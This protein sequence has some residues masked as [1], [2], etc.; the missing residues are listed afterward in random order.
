MKLRIVHIY[1]KN[2]ALRTSLIQSTIVHIYD[3]IAS[4]YL[5]IFNIYALNHAFTIPLIPIH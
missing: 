5:F 2:N 1:D 4:L 3:K